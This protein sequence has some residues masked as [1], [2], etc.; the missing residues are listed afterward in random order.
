M[1]PCDAQRGD[2]AWTCSRNLKY[3]PDQLTSPCCCRA[4]PRLPSLA[5][6]SGALQAHLGGWQEPSGILGRDW[7]PLATE[8]HPAPELSQQMTLPHG[9]RNVPRSP[10]L[11]ST[12]SK[13]PRIFSHRKTDCDL[14]EL[15]GSNWVREGVEPR[16][17]S[18]FLGQFLH[19]ISCRELRGR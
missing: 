4:S 7:H 18:G 14:P 19:K 3:A 12:S 10:G 2:N 13:R 15:L 5:K 9:R 17:S 11:F 16:P 6:G 1:A 8:S